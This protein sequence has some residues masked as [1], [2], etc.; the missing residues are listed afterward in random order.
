MRTPFTIQISASNAT[1]VTPIRA[2]IYIDDISDG[3]YCDLVNSAPKVKEGFWNEDLDELHYFN[4]EFGGI[5][6]NNFLDFD[7]YIVQSSSCLASE[8]SARQEKEGLRI[9]SQTE[10]YNAPFRPGFGAVSAYFFKSKQVY[11]ENVACN[12][13][14][15][16]IDSRE[17]NLNDGLVYQIKKNQKMDCE[18][19]RDNLHLEVVDEHQP[20]AVLHVHYRP[21]QWLTSRGLIRVDK[22]Q[23]EAFYKSKFRAMKYVDLNSN[24]EEFDANK[25]KKE[26]KTGDQI[27]SKGIINKVKYRTNDFFN[28]N[29]GKNTLENY[30][31]S[32][33]WASP[34][35]SQAEIVNQNDDL[36]I[37]SQHDFLDTLK[38]KQGF[39]SSASSLLQGIEDLQPGL[40]NNRKRKRISYN[41]FVELLDSE[42]E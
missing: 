23:E 4:F 38:R 35:M 29:L 21:L 1:P 33:P 34:E 16:S 28:V 17:Y 22:S 42:D 24:G 12:P 26:N 19:I 36:Q 14:S 2:E 8:L 7:F 40:E 39:D 25:N 3:T 9:P 27:K 5:E 30:K 15:T 37:I 41:E 18:V 6:Y 31:F 20:L 11:K 32:F 10:A 13:E